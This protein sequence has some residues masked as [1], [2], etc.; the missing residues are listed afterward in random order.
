MKRQIWALAL[1]ALAGAA[2]AEP[3]KPPAAL[4]IPFTKY[5]LANGLTVILSEDHR[6]PLV[7]VDVWYH[8][9]PVQEA[10]GRTGFAHLF[11][12]LMFQGSKHVADDQ[13][14]ALLEAAGASMINGTTDFDRTNYFETVPKNQLDLALWLESDRMGF[15]LDTMSQAKLDNQRDVVQNERRQSIENV[16]YGLAEERVFQL[17]F[18]KGHPYYGYVIGSHADLEATKLDDVVDFLQEVLRPGQRLAGDLRRLRRQEGAQ[19]GRQVVRRSSVGRGRWRAGP[20]EHTRRRDQQ[21]E[22]RVAHR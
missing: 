17:L 10:P 2:Q 13:H 11:E 6:L 3:A 5:K 14:F 15:L 22:A 21:G 16:P 20:A 9:G 1:V 18:P 7:A 12:H 8:V 19:A 4:S